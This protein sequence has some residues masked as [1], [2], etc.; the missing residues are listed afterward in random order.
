MTPQYRQS[1]PVRTRNDLDVIDRIDARIRGFAGSIGARE[2]QYPALIARDVLDQSEYPEAFPHLLM[3]ASCSERLP[4]RETPESESS[5][6]GAP[7]NTISRISNS[8]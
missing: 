1:A 7:S 6:T 4:A 8:I 5:C 3:A 2:M